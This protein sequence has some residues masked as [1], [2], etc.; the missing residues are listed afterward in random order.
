MTAGAIGKFQKRFGGDKWPMLCGDLILRPLS[1]FARQV[2][3]ELFVFSV[4][5]VKNNLA[6]Y[7]EGTDPFHRII[8]PK[9]ASF[10]KQ[11][12]EQLRKCTVIDQTSLCVTLA[13]LSRQARLARR[14]KDILDHIFD[15]RHG[16]RTAG[17][18]PLEKLRIESRRKGLGEFYVAVPG[19]EFRKLVRYLKLRPE[20]YAFIDF[21][22]GKDELSFMRWTTIFAVS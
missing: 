18:I 2:A 9:G 17:I 21:G 6:R 16:T 5:K 15:K 14:V 12:D 4:L 20:K 19:Y 1:F 3:P 7:F 8:S 10:G 13:W 22:C 11:E